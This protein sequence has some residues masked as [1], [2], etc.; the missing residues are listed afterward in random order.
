VPRLVYAALLLLSL[1]W[2]GSFYFIKM[3]LHDFGPWTIAFLRSGSGLVV[4]IGMMLILKKPFGFR[5]IPWLPVAFMAL[6]NTAIPWALIAYSE[7]H[8]TSSM[9]SI[10]NT[11][12]PVW[13]I[14][15]G[16]LLFG[17]TSSRNQWFGV[18]VATIGLM[19]LLDLRPGAGMTLVVDKLG[20]LFMLGATF[21]YAVGSQLSKRL[22]MGY[23]M[24]QISMGTLL[25]S[26][27]GSGS[28]ALATESISAGDILSGTNL[29]MII[30]LGVFGSGFAY[31]LFYYMVQKGSAEF[32]S[33]VTYLVP[34][35]ALIWGYT[36]LNEEIKWNM[37]LGLLIILGGVFLAGRRGNRG[38][39]S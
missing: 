27:I 35:T 18:A 11:M 2:G 15:V 29:P 28:V 9:A 24:Y 36:L 26:M 38:K 1:I 19:V 39:V 4:V 16:I 10:L 22:L 25:T 30:G 21:C 14:V 32:A 31:I 12:T 6:I 34:S 5:A 17:H 7:T 8:L 3:L 37:L 23:S 13:T 33:M 20:L